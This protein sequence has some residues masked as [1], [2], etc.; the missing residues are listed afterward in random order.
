MAHKVLDVYTALLLIITSCIRKH[1][2]SNK[3]QDK[4]LHRSKGSK[5]QVFIQLH[6][7]APAREHSTPQQKTKNDPSLF[8]FFGSREKS[9]QRITSTCYGDKMLKI[10]NKAY[11]G[12][13]PL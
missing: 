4:L 12:L 3:R 13:N 2:H 9:L 6:F 7:L 11:V 10:T 5:I 1:N 8:D